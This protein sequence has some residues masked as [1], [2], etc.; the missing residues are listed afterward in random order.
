[1]NRIFY[2]VLDK[3][4]YRLPTKYRMELQ[5]L[6]ENGIEI[7]IEDDRGNIIIIYVTQ[8]GFYLYSTKSMIEAN[9]NSFN[10]YM[11]ASLYKIDS[12]D[13]LYQIIKSRRQIMTNKVLRQMMR[14]VVRHAKDFGLI[15]KVPT[16]L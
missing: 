11:R 4:D 8:D 6:A 5:K 13:E 15:K 2:V 3:Y 10:Y 12:F 7:P 1:M 14:E 9:Y 16:Y